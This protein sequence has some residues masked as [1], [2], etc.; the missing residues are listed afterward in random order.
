MK[1]KMKKVFISLLIIVALF[2]MTTISAFAAE[3]TVQH[4]NESLAL[5]N[6]GLFSGISSTTYSPN[7]TA[8]LNRTEGVIFV[9]KL[10]GKQHQVHDISLT[11]VSSI[12]AR[13]H[14]QADIPK[15]ARSYVAY[16]VKT[17]MIIGTNLT[18]FSPM[19]P[20]SGS[21]Y[22]TM[23]LRDLGWKINAAGYSAAPVTLEQLGAPVQTPGNP[24]TKGS[25]IVKF[26]TPEMLRDGAVGIALNALNAKFKAEAVAINPL[27]VQP[28]DGVGV[29]GKSLL[30]YEIAN[31]AFT[32]TKAR[33]QLY[34]FK[35][36]DTKIWQSYGLLP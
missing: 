28:S 33:K 21:A 18:E 13:F 27:D 17:H 16:A 26:S 32:A 14:D 20:L 29:L 12:L 25:Q 15:W 35:I 7:L 24:V 10:F 23:I 1:M 11:E 36:I 30:E 5:Y 8:P 31:G 2:S 34:G 6:L 9:I 4:W 3:G 19:K 22:C